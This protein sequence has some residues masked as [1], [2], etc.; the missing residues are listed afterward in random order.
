MLIIY[1]LE[2]S[3]K[4]CAVC[5]KE[6]TS[7]EIRINEIGRKTALKKTRYLCTSCRR[8]EY[9]Q[10]VKAVKELIKKP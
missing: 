9:E 4:F 3:S 5:G 6:L 1:S 7:T 2:L 8:R 10:Y